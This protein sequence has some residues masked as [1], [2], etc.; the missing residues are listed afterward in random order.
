MHA[1]I[2]QYQIELRTDGSA[3]LVDWREGQSWHFTG[4]YDPGERLVSQLD[5]HKVA[6]SLG[7]CAEYVGSFLEAIKAL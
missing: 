3:D 5:C 4:G 7:E 6:T 2:N 1:M